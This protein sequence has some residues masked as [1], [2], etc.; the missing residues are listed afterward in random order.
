M[1]GLAFF[2]SGDPNIGSGFELT[3]IAA[4]VIGGTP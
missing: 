2:I 1:L 3:A 4:A